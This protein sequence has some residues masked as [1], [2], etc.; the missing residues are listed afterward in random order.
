MRYSVEMALD[1]MTNIHTK[2]HE[3]WYRRSSNS[4]L[5]LRNMKGNNDGRQL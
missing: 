3:D 2:F 4:K 1:G 5:F